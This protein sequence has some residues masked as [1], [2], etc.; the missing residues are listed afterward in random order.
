M[1]SHD[2]APQLDPQN[3]SK[4]QPPVFSARRLSISPV[5]FSKKHARLQD[6][7]TDT[8]TDTDSVIHTNTYSHTQSTTHRI[9][10]IRTSQDLCGND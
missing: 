6:T 3:K 10:R 4:S 9:K 2:T 8:N 7:D 1:S 5:Q